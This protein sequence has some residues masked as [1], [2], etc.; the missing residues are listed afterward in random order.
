MIYYI[1]SIAVHYNYI[2]IAIVRANS[3]ADY[4][5]RLISSW[6]KRLKVSR[7]WYRWIDDDHEYW[8][9]RILELQNE[10]I[11]IIQAVIIKLECHFKTASIKDLK[12]MCV[13]NSTKL[14]E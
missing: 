10:T 12:I 11:S 3:S 8:L 14:N 6:F 9:I 4:N 7:S 5:Y 13:T 2:G 1:I